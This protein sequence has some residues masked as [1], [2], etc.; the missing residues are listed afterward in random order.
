MKSSSRN[1]YFYSFCIFPSKATFLFIP[2]KYYFLFEALQNFPS[3]GPCIFPF[4]E[5]LFFLLK[6]ALF[7]FPKQSF[8][9]FR[10]GLIFFPKNHCSYDLFPSVELVMSCFYRKLLECATWHNL[11]FRNNISS[12]HRISFQAHAYMLPLKCAPRGCT[13]WRHRKLP[14]GNAGK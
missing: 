4:E 7:S 12:S 9:F 13:T 2:K 1:K 3:E 10:R 14:H 11:P 6:R 8:Y 5:A